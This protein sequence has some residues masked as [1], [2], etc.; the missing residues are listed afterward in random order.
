MVGLREIARGEWPPYLSTQYTTR[1]QRKA[2]RDIANCRTETMGTVLHTCEKCG[3]EYR[4]YRSCRNRSCPLCGGES[5]QKWLAA[6]R[7][8]ILPVP[9]LHVVFTPPAELNVLARYCP[10]AIYGAVMRAAGQTIIDVGYSKLQ[11]QLG[12][13]VHLHTWG[14]SMAFHLHAHCAVPCGGFSEDGRWVS[15][16]TNDL[17][18]KTLRNRFR[19]LLLENIRAAAEQ[20][21]LD[22]LP[23][24]VSVQELL[25]MVRSRKWRVY[26][27]PPFGGA[28]K[29]FEYLSRYTYR[30][31]ITNDRIESYENHQVTFRYRD[32]HHRNEE[33]LYTLG[34]QEFLRRFLMHVP[35]RRFVRIRSYGLLGNRNRKKNVERARQ[36]IGQ[37][38][39]IAPSRADFQPLRLCPACFAESRN[40]G[41]R[42]HFALS[43]EVASQLGFTLRAPPPR[44][45]AA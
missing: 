21:E 28:E 1:D 38:Q 30:V 17:P 6:R 16:G 8:E 22:R 41:R 33:K 5:R 27:E 43:P 39:P 37:A 12:C 13:S 19:S 35:P 25:E 23:S 4:L 31:A 45:L 26:A 24:N 34:G 18:R 11:A 9:Y 36:L 29:L 44:A 7:Q 14:Q 10:G 20:G 32:Y 15:F 2:I 3:V 40:E 42:P